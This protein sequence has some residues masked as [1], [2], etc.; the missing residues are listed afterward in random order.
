MTGTE[1]FWLMTI[2]L[3]L[4]LDVFVLIQIRNSLITIELLL[5]RRD[6]E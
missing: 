5:A 6:G 3:L 4:A 1:F 2:A